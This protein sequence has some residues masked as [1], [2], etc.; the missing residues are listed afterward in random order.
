MGCFFAGCCFGRATDVPWAVTFTQRIRGAERRHAA[1]YSDPSRRSSTRPA[2]SCSSWDSCCCMERK[3]R[4][5]PGPDLLGLPSALRD[6]PVH[7]RVLPR[8]CARDGRGP[9]DVAV[10]LGDPGAAQHPDAGRSLAALGAGPE[11]RGEAGP[12]GIDHDHDRHARRLVVERRARRAPAGQLSHRPAARPLALADPAADQGRPRA[13]SRHAARQPCRPRPG[14]STSSRSRSRPPA[15]P[16]PEELPLRII[17]QDADV[18]VLDKPAGMVVHPAA[19]H[20][21]RHA[22]ERAAAPRQGPERRRRRAA[23]R[24]SSTGWIAEHPA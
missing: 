15:L 23:A 21:R 7:H 8:G 18:V 2:R 6:H 1:E 22:G 19:G 11:D 13:R 3:G 10:R 17:F 4:R 14:R 16:E 20:T 24:A 5:V 9:V 12:G